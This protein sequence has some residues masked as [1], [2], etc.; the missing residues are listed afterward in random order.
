VSRLPDIFDDY[1]VPYENWNHL[2]YLYAID[3]YTLVYPQ[4]LAN[5][6]RAQKEL[7]P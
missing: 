7:V 3:A 4:L 5:M 1:E 2:D 6:E